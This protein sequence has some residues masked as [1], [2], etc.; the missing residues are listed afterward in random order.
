MYAA[1]RP[2]GLDVA[3]TLMA[4]GENGVRGKGAPV[5]DAVVRSRAVV[6]DEMALRH[7][8]VGAS[9]EPE[10]AG[11]IDDLVAA[12]EQLAKLVVRG[13]GASQEEYRI[14]VARARDARDAAERAVAERSLGAQREQRQQRVGLDAVQAALPERSALVAFVRYQEFAVRAPAPSDRR[15]RSTAAYLAFVVRAG[16]AGTPAVVPLGPAAAIDDEIAQWRKQLKAVAFAGGRSTVRAEAAVR[17]SGAR[18]RA[19]IWDP[20]ASHVTDTT[21]IFIVPDGP[22]HLVSWDALPASGAGYL[23]EQAPPFHYL[24]AERDLV[25]D[26]EPAT[27]RGLLIVD[28]PVFD[29]APSPPGRA[30]NAAARSSNERTAPADRSTFRGSTLDC[31]DFQSMRFDPLPASAREAATISAIWR[32][33]RGAAGASDVSRLSG[34]DATEAEVKRGAV[35]ARV[36]HLATHGFF[37]GGRCA[38]A[39][40]RSADAQA[41]DVAAARSIG[42]NPLLLAGFA[43]TGAN[44]RQVAGIEDEDGILTAEEIASLPLGG[45]EWAVLSACD[46]GVGE[47]RAGEGVFGLRRAFQVAGAR[48]VI[49]SLWPVDDED[50]LRWMTSVYQRRFQRGAGTME[51]VRGSSLEQLRRRRRAGLSTHP[52]YWAAFIAAGDWR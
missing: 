21:R 11:L 30:T 37:L 36:L 2:V 25:M 42:T 29:R 22:L 44:R 35:G 31:G 33:A 16:D 14:E 39:L 23:I 48:T 18:L 1:A 45:V 17:R 9:E 5:W 51:A 26:A 47:V 6:L 34:R 28:G 24:S 12:R 10:V 3:L 49:M 40:D 46:T 8:R 19:S 15:S 20:L 4:R 7:R 43:L 50:A 32:Q 13:P 38:S 27:G 41:H 52:F